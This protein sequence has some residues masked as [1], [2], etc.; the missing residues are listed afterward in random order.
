MLIKHGAKVNACTN[1]GDTALMLA[2]SN[3]HTEVVRLLI[4]NG[5]YV[6]ACSE[7]PCDMT[8]ALIS[9]AFDGH[10]DVV[11]VLIKH[12]ANINARSNNGITALT[13]ATSN[14]HID[15]VHVLTEAIQ[16]AAARLIQTR[17]RDVNTCP[18]HPV[19]QRRLQREFDDCIVA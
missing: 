12:K 4:D 14:G 15:V 3:G 7:D 9:A 18:T 19:C 6:N 5:A 11:R 1:L 16:D 10:T 13:Y 8:T 2:S 17:W